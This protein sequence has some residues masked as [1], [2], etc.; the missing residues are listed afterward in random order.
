MGWSICTKKRLMLVETK[1]SIRASAR[2]ASWTVSTKEAGFLK[3][4]P[5]ALFH[6]VSN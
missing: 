3:G 6:T 5:R 1:V 2:H 4:A